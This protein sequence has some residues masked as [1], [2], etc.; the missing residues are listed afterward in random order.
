[1]SGSASSTRPGLGG[2]LR[3]RPNREPSKFKPVI[4]GGQHGDVAIRGEHGAAIGEAIGTSSTSAIIDT[5]QLT[6]GDRTRFFTDFAETLLRKNSGPLT[7]MIDEAH[8]FMPQAGAKAG[9]AAPAMLHAGNNLV[10]LGRGVGLRIV[11]VSQRPAKLHKDSLTQVETLVAMRLL[12]NLDVDAVRA[13]I[14]EWAAPGQ[15][16]ELVA[17]LPSLG[18]GDAWVWSPELGVLER[19]H[20]P[21]VV[22]FD[23]GKPPKAGE[24]GPAL[25]PIDITAIAERLMAIGKE[26]IANDPRQLKARITEL[27]RK[28]RDAAPGSVDPASLATAERVTREIAAIA[29]FHAGYMAGVLRE[30]EIGAGSIRAEVQSLGESAESI[31]KA[32]SALV[33]AIDG[34]QRSRNG[35][36]PPADVLASFDPAKLTYKSTP[37]PKRTA[38]VETIIDMPGVTTREQAKRL[39]RAAHGVQPSLGSPAVQYGSALSGPE[40]KILDA[41]RWWNVLGIRAPSHAQTAFI[42]GYSHK[43][44]TWATYL[45]RL[46]S[47]G[48]I[49]GRGD[50]VLTSV[51]RQMVHEPDSPPTG[52]HLRAVVLGKISD[53]LQRILLPIIHAYPKSLSHAAVA[54]T[55]GY[56]HKS[57]TWATYLSRLR[58]L[59]LIDGRG[60]L[61]AQ[62]WLFPQ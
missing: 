35:L 3:L 54:D 1:M 14:G 39:G 36:E 25:K 40:Q 29:G 50:L 48:F 61:R 5:R 7:L 11:L 13:W 53:P 4:F 6:V 62:D 18:V 55:A 42:A 26:V 46:R 21:L 47:A 30:R 24:T 44:G 52:E 23:S 38:S 20:F 57:G 37:V 41:I 27:E 33:K 16:K 2:G 9:G 49:E 8:L 19:A 59:D 56:S 10:S 34:D 22:T 17:S 51:G 32:L 12:H 58:T 31:G 15:G 28:A 43:S 60:E 45:S